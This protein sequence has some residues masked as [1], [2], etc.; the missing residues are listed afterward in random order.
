MKKSTASSKP[1][2]RVY[3]KKSL[4]KTAR[5]YLGS[6]GLDFDKESAAVAE[7]VKLHSASQKPAPANPDT[8]TNVY[9]FT[10][11]GEPV[12]EPPSLWQR[13]IKWLAR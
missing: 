2:R 5:A 10:K 12:A 8:A 7:L 13:F 3:R 4:P 6:L 9:V 1:P 11:P